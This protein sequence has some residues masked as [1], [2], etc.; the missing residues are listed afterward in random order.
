[1]GL[2]VL[3][4]VLLSAVLIIN[5]KFNSKKEKSFALP[6]IESWEIDRSDT[7]V[8][9]GGRL[10]VFRGCADCHGANLGGK[11]FLDDPMIGKI[12][13]PNITR[14]KGGLPADWSTTDWVRAL[15]HGVKRDGKSLLIMPSYETTHMSR[16]DMGAVIA[17]IEQVQPVD[18]EW[19]ETEMKPLGKLLALLDELP[20]F[21][22]EKID[23]TAKLVPAMEVGPTAAYGEYLAVT[24]T[25]CHRT[26][27]RGGKHPVPG[28]PDVTNITGHGELANYRFA[29]FKL[30]LTTGKRPNGSS[31]NAEAMPW[32]MLTV[33]NDV[34]LEA[35]FIY[36]KSL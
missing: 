14:G 3:L 23:H 15:K 7:S 11:L 32:P 33:L 26:D 20:T 27:F 19:G 2:S 10:S 8:E 30:A 18:A 16:Q 12:Y 9:L 13:T 35:L 17:Y 28:L 25:G 22:A 5:L 24:C 31:M 4:L 21:I 1:M 36:L 29:D 6:E 34:E